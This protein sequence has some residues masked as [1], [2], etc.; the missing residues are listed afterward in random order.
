MEKFDYYIKDIHPSDFFS[1][2]ID[3]IKSLKSK[4]NSLKFITKGDKLVIE[5]LEDE[6]MRACIV[7][8][9]L[10]FFIK[11]NENISEANISEIINGNGDNC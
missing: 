9:S 1:N 6:I 4:F 5:G 8:D 7:L 11:K 10:T 2:E 3:I